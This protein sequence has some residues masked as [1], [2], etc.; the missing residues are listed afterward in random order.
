M[1]ENERMTIPEFLEARI[2]EDEAQATKH[3]PALSSHGLGDYGLR[4]LSECAAKRVIVGT[5]RAI[6]ANRNAEG[7]IQWHEERAL[8]TSV[9]ALAAVYKDHPDYQAEWAL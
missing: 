2:A 8:L 6:E 1:S 3:L 9:S 4:V 7:S 5:Y